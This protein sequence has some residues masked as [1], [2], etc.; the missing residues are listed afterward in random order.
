VVGWRYFSWASR[1]CGGLCHQVRDVSQIVEEINERM[2][3][4]TLLLV[5]TQRWLDASYRRIPATHTT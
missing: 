4:I 3:R 1:N 5:N 2:A